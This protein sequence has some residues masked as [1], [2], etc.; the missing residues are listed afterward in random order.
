VS[1][2]FIIEL[3]TYDEIAGYG[4]TTGQKGDS[5]RA[6]AY[7]LLITFLMNLYFM[8]LEAMEKWFKDKN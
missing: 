3:F 6:R 1:L 7:V 8:V 4:N 2:Y 5:R